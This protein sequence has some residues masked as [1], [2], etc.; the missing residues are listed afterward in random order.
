MGKDPITSPIGMP[1][2]EPPTKPV[3]MRARLADDCSHSVPSSASSMV[4]RITFHGVGKGP[5]G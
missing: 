1:I 2:S 3:P 4:L 5:T